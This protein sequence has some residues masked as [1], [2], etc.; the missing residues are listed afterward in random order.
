MEDFWIAYA[1]VA[2][3]YALLVCE[4]IALGNR[5]QRREEQRAADAERKRAYDR[6]AKVLHRWPSSGAR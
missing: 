4:L 6:F 3:I 1:I 5:M 2:S